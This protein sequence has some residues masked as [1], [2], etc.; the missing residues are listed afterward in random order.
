MGKHMIETST[1]KALAAP[2]RSTPPSSHLGHLGYL[3]YLG[4]LR[5][6]SSPASLSTTKVYLRSLRMRWLTGSPAILHPSHVPPPLVKQ[7]AHGGGTAAARLAR[8]VS[9]ATHLCCR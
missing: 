1:R 9:D 5:T 7:E 8:A 6:C 2:R 4:Q 3:G